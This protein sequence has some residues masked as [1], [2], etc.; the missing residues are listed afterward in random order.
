[1]SH[2]PGRR[3]AAAAP[4]SPVGPG[5]YRGLLGTAW[6]GLHPS[7]QRIHAGVA[8]VEGSGTFRIGRGQT[9]LA[10]CLAGIFRMPA[11][12]DG[13]PTG[14]IVDPDDEG[15]TWH[16]TFGEHRM[17]SRQR[18]LPDG[19]L[20]ERIGPLEF[21]FRLLPLD[22]GIV[23]EQAAVALRV[24]RWRGRL[25]RWIAPRVAA[26][27]MPAPGH[28]GMTTVWVRVTSPLCGN[29]LSYEGE[30]GCEPR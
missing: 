21:R 28:A 11:A 19:M 7:V 29:L 30:M 3:A 25:P 16:R 24:G 12:A 4:P 23:Y 9:L 17:I 1:M 6:S 27:E 13:V 10:R 15:E 22:G 5:L 20:A 8:R 14:L 26:R 18:G 2:H